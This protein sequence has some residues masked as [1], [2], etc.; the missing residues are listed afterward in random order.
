[1]RSAGGSETVDFFECALANNERGDCIQKVNSQSLHYGTAM[2]KSILFIAALAG[3]ASLLASGSCHAA[4]VYAE[5]FTAKNV[6]EDAKL[7]VTAPLRWDVNDWLYFGG[8]LAAVGAAHAYDGDVRRHFA[9][10][11]RAVL[12]GQDKDSL[13]DAIP[14]AAVVAGTWA[15]AALI[16]DRA[17]EVE[18]YTMLE[19]AGF[20]L[21]TAE[22]LKYAAGRE[23]PD[24][25]THVNMWRDG[26]SSFPSFHAT[27]AFAVGTVLAESGGDDYRWLRRILGYGMATATAYARLH[28][29]VHWLSDTVA[30]AAVGIATARFAMNR[31]EERKQRWDLSVAPM[32]GGGTQLTW[33]MDLN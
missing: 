4:D 3:W 15:V 20:S 29:N 14:A 6:L 19:A 31:R 5:D 21:V 8:A 1:M 11:G 27:A 16:G 10:G 2:R 25:T 12:N 22:G 7:Y 24:E 26:G 23:R 28:E 18:S 13:R 9:V 32:A 30:G 17:G 33:S